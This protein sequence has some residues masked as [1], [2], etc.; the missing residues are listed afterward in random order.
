MIFFL[1]SEPPGGIPFKAPE[2]VHHARWMAKVLYCFMIYMFR[3]YEKAWFKTESP[4]EAPRIDLKILPRHKKCTMVHLA[5]R[6]A[7]FKK[8]VGHLWYLSEVLIGLASFDENVSFDCKREMVRASKERRSTETCK[9]REDFKQ[10]LE[11]VKAL[12]VTN[13]SAERGVAL[14]SEY[15]ALITKYEGQEQHLIQVVKKHREIFPGCNKESL[16]QS[17][18]E[19]IF[20]Q[21]P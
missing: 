8:L 19:F 2:A 16:K 12:S 3:V 11:V 14:M 13:E 1:G 15:N 9:E 20:R 10:G 17:F 6:E 18:E 5:I 4:T 21:A 7:V